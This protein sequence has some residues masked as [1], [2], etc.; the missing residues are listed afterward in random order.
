M[1]EVDEGSTNI[2]NLRE[3]DPL[4]DSLILVL[5]G[6]G[7]LTVVATA[8]FWWATRPQRPAD[9]NHSAPSQPSKGHA[10]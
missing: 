5:I 7:G 4:L 3:T 6:L 8:L 1:Q 10:T 2:I 9:Q